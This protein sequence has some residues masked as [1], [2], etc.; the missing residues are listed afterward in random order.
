MG[1]FGIKKKIS[2]FTDF[3]KEDIENFIKKAT[4]YL[5]HKKKISF[6]YDLNSSNETRLKNQVI[7]R[8]NA[9]AGNK[10]VD[11]AFDDTYINTD[12]ISYNIFKNKKKIN[13]INFCKYYTKRSISKDFVSFHIYL[14]RG[15][16]KNWHKYEHHHGVGFRFHQRYNQFGQLPSSEHLDYSDFK[17]SPIGISY[18]K[19]KNGK[20]I[21][22]KYQKPKW[23]EKKEFEDYKNIKGRG[24][25][26]FQEY[27]KDQ[28]ERII[29]LL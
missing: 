24:H 8:A 5:D 6:E 20:S 18:M 9:Y 7:P 2:K 17:Y 3:E 1:F 23:A 10:W 29:K 11:R 27:L 28:R 4:L 16:D 19:D 15:D 21:N 14:E 26:D 22:R 12:L 13:I 25:E